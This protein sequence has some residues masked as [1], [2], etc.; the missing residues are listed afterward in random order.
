[1]PK[2]LKASE[3]TV[4]R[5]PTIRC[6]MC[7]GVIVP[8]DGTELTEHYEREHPTAIARAAAASR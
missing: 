6:Q 8:K 5:L 1:M 2:K 4:S 7:G 3:V